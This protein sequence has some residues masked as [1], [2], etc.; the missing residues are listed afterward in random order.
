MVT[1]NRIKSL[2]IGGKIIAGETAIR[3]IVVC[4]M[5]CGPVK[6]YSRVGEY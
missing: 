3:A 6:E 1:I 2:F 5:P 4:P